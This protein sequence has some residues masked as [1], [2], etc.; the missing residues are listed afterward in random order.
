MVRLE[1]GATT[2]IAL[3]IDGSG[4]EIS[5]AATSVGVTGGGATVAVAGPPASGSATVDLSATSNDREALLQGL[6]T[7]SP[8][9]V[10]S[11]LGSNPSP[12]S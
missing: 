10:V 9:S 1:A 5:A 6:I 7:L 2:G 11:F 12:P 8:V 4:L 3:Q